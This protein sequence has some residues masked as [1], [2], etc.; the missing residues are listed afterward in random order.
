MDGRRRLLNEFA[1]MWALRERFPLHLIVFKQTACHLPHEATVEMLFSRAGLL[2]DPNMDPHFL[3]TLTSIAANKKAYEPSWE[4][5]KA[6]YFEK[7][8]GKGPRA[9]RPRA[10]PRRA[11]RGVALPIC[12]SLFPQVSGFERPYLDN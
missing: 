3:A 12:V 10:S 5:I 7:F 9:A 4:K 6:K 1:M 2:T 8:R 11:R